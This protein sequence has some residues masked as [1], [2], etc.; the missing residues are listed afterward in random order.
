MNK[1]LRGSQLAQTG[2][3]QA[4]SGLIRPRPETGISRPLKG[5]EK[6]SVVVFV[7]AVLIA[8]VGAA[9]LQQNLS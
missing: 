6:L 2:T 4:F 5:R 9:I 1:E 8:P 7:G 3:E